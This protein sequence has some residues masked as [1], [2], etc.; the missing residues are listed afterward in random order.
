[1]YVTSL[2]V[3]VVRA[4]WCVK[5]NKLQEKISSLKSITFGIWF[6]VGLVLS[7]GQDA[8]AACLGTIY[9]GSTYG[10]VRQHGHTGSYCTYPAGR[11]VTNGTSVYKVLYGSNSNQSLSNTGQPSYQGACIS[12][13]APTNISLSNSSINENARANATVGTL[14]ATDA[15]GGPMIYAITSGGTNFNIS[16]STLRA[17]NTDFLEKVGNKREYSFTL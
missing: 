10:N 13:T 8:D 7:V 6:F 14:S 11:K 3:L 2:R 9:C 4:V 15:Q 12:N 16:G 5:M 17:T 1:M